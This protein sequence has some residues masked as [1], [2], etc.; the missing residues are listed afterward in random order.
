MRQLRG[1]VAAA[2]VY[3]V[4]TLAFTWPLVRGLAHDLPADLGDPLLNCWV[5]SWDAD[6][7]L[8]AIT[9]DV[10]A[11]GEYW[12]ANIFYPHPRT[13]A[14]SEHLTPQAITIL[15]VYAI[16]KNPVLC[17]NLVFLSTFVLS[18]LGM[19]LFALDVTG[20][21]GAAFLAGVAYGFA[22]YRFSALSHIQVLS[23]MWMP[24]ALFGFQRFF[25]TRRVRPLAIGTAAWVAQNLSCGYYLL[26][27]SPVLLLYFLWELTR[28]KSWTDSRVLYRL[29]AATVLV[30]AVTAPF[31]FPYFELRQLG[32]A[33]RSIG[34]A[35]RFSA[36]VYAYA[37][38][39]IGMRLWGNVIRSW[40]TPEGSLF[41][42]FAIAALATV[43]LAERWWSARGGNF[44]RAA[45]PMSAHVLPWMLTVVAG[46]F[47]ALLL[48]WSLRAIVAGVEIKVT[49]LYRLIVIGAILFAALIVTSYQSRATARRWFGSHVGVLATLTAFAMAMSFGPQ[50]R[51]HGRL[52]AE[53][54]LYGVFYNVVPGFDGLRVP[55]RYGMIVAFGLSGLAGC[56]AAV[57]ARQ[58]YGTALG[59]LATALIVAESWAVPIPL[60]LNSTEYKQSG[61]TPLPG[62]LAFGSAGPLVYRFVAQLPPASA[63]IEF[64]FG[65]VAFEARYMF[66]SISHWRPLVNGYSG[67]APKEYGLWAERFKDLLDQ[68]EPAWQAVLESRATHLV[69]HEASYAGDRGGRISQWALA[70]GARELAVFGTDRLFSIAGA[71]R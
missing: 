62:T 34:E 33:P 28:R 5:L 69:V 31:V 64:P 39:D 42:G 26:F 32:F 58:R 13:L 38:I 46:L 41:P 59:V 19:F 17:Y 50:I 60:N 56:G 55:A 11:L 14:Y 6:H 68:P 23:S 2:A 65:E 36:D 30:A 61:L 12:N 51:S 47:V 71:G 3:T 18:A 8:R 53:E 44:S 43:A 10:A 57:L 15:P 52:I 16:T 54:N 7:M 48:G 35:G 22:P 25:D 67:G 70:H 40:P 20:S 66:Q 27:F 45:R 1:A 21:R 29:A 4:L 37:T 9:G 63:L 49:S 24:F